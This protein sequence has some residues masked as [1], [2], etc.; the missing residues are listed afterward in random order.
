MISL[1]TCQNYLQAFRNTRVR[2]IYSN[3]LQ[4]VWHC[5][6]YAYLTALFGYITR[7]MAHMYK[8]DGG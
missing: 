1:K 8:H 3:S 6:M 7:I 4:L 2:F 5:V